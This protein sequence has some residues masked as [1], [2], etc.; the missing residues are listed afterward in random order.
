MGVR[1]SVAGMLSTSGSFSHCFLS[2]PCGF[3]F[4][5]KTEEEE[6]VVVCTRAQTSELTLERGQPK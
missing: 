4:S 1:G 3:L 2:L 5:S 6:E